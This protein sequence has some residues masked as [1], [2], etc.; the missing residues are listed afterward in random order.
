MKLFIKLLKTSGVLLSI[1]LLQSD[2]CWHFE[3]VKRHYART[4]QSL[5][6]F[7]ALA[8][9][10]P[11]ARLRYYHEQQGWS[12]A[13]KL[14]YLKHPSLKFEAQAHFLIAQAMFQARMFEQALI[15]TQG[16]A[17]AN[18]QRNRELQGRILIALELYEQAKKAL[19]G[20]RGDIA[21]ALLAEIYLATGQL[22]QAASLLQNNRSEHGIKLDHSLTTLMDAQLRLPV[23]HLNIQFLVSDYKGLVYADK[24]MRRWQQDS[25]VVSLPVCFNRTVSFDAEQV[26][27]DDLKNTRLSCELTLMARHIQIP[28][29][30]LPVVIYGDKGQAN[31]N[32]GIIFINHHKRYGVFKH[33]LMHH[34]GFMDEYPLT[35]VVRARLCHREG[36]GWVGENLYIMPAN[37]PQGE[38]PDKMVPVRACEGT[39]SQAYKPVDMMTVM[40]FMDQPLPSEYSQK[41]INKLTAE[42]GLLANYQYAYALAFAR[43]GEQASYRFWLEKSAQSGY[44]IARELLDKRHFDGI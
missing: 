17:L 10:I 18:D 23:C 37:T 29:K 36:P 41:A 26:K 43:K 24:L 3:R 42:D 16:S 8:L 7:Q 40:E 11:Q 12:L 19:F 30:T 32:N 33:E 1:L 25:S 15:W 14:R 35:G 2:L 28:A 20:L 9:D 27:C 39:S 5:L 31:Y 13:E 34:F 21:E 4:P 22:H 6:Y 44:K 38:L